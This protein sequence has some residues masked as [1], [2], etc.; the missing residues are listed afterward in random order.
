M[1]RLNRNFLWGDTLE[2]Q[3]IHL[4]NWDIVTTPKS[5]GGLGIK[6][7]Q[8]RNKSLLAKH[9]WALQ[10]GSKDYW[11]HTLKAKYS[12]N[13]ARNRPSIIWRSLEVT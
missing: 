11:A 2:K 7:S 13:L 10:L 8:C 9:L 4:A 6:R 1:D 12:S 5:H 3:K